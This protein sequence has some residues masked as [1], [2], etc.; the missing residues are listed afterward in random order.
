MEKTVHLKQKIPVV[1]FGTATILLAGAFRTPNYRPNTKLDIRHYTDALKVKYFDNS[2]AL[3]T[4]PATYSFVTETLKKYRI[5]PYAIETI[6]TKTSVCYVLNNGDK[7]ERVGGTLAWRNNNPGC[8]RYSAN[9]VK[10]GAIGKANG[11]AIF[12]DEKT[13]MRAIETLLCSD[14]YCDLSIGAAITKYAPPHENDTQSYIR[15]LSKMTGLPIKSKI[16][17]L[18]AEQI[19][20]VVK[21]IKILEGWHE[22][23]ETKIPALAQEKLQEYDA[24]RV[25]QIVPFILGLEK[26]L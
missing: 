2:Y 25:A 23:T 24:I 26:T 18:N 5:A 15:K 17:D 12:P 16:C 13:G 1:L 11:F 6:S 14:A 8:I 3:S 19:K 21:T 10:M 22:G 20:Q 9:A 7:I 4:T